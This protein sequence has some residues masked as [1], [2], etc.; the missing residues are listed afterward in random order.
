MDIMNNVNLQREIRKEGSVL[1]L[2]LIV[3][4]SLIILSVGLAYR[5]QIEIRLAYANAQR[6]QA[7]YLA[8]GGIERIKALL[9]QEELS[10]STIARICQF[11]STAK[12]EGLF[13]Q[14]KD[15][16]LNEGKLL[17][18]SLR[19]EQRYLNLNN[20]DPASWVNID[21]ISEECCSVILDWIDEDNDT[22][23]GGAET[24]FYERLEL[25]YISKDAP[26][27]ALKELLFLKGVTRDI[28]LGEDLNRN[29][30]L[31]ENERDGW[32]Q[33]PFDNEDNKLDFGLLD[34]FT[35]Y[36]GGKVNI[37]TTSRVILDALP[38][39]GDEVVELIL[40]YRA[41]PDGQL[42]TDDDMCFTSSEDIAN[43]EGLTELQ[44]ELLKQYCC[45]DSEYFRIFSSAGLNNTFKCCLMATV[46]CTES[47]PQI[48]YLERL[49]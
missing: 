6:T 25:P 39:L 12:E 46:K 32:F 22:G 26:F 33:V 11:T 41:G 4:S 40:T 7:Y 10:P 48:L 44:I 49:L 36:G 9:S 16:D 5:T 45:F 27:V 2:V 37:N 17:T 20:S 8:L 35:V 43:V 3:L 18:Y 38:G 1:V 14:L 19:D 28:Y 47:R 31:D 24:D 13:E 29:S 21:Y 15:F 23:P 30:F 42:G 34:T